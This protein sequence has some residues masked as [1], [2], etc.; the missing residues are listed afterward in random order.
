MNGNFWSGTFD[1]SGNELAS[2]EMPENNG[3]WLRIGHAEILVD[4]SGERVFAATTV[5]S[6][7]KDCKRA[8]SG[9]RIDRLFE[10]QRTTQ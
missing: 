6:C 2:V 7:A 3:N 5:T 4:P 1:E 8:Q 10:E 9:V